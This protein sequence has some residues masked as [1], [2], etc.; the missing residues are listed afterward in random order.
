MA[1]SLTNVMDK[2]LARGL[3]ALRGQTI[4]PSLVNS[5]YSTDAAEKG[6]T[7]DVPVPV[8]QAATAVS[9][10][11]TPPADTDNTPKK[12]QISL[13]QWYS[14]DFH[15]T[16]KE[17]AE[18]DRNRHFF[19]M[20]ASEAIKALASQVNTNIFSHYTGVYGFAGTSGTTPFASTINVAGT[21]AKQL[22][23]QLAPLRDRRMVIDTAAHANAIVLAPL[24]DASQQGTRETIMEG[25]I[26][27]VMG[28][29]WAFD[30]EVPTHTAGTLSDGSGRT[31]LINNGAGYAV[32]T[33]TVNID[34]TSL[35]GTLVTGDIIDFGV[36]GEFYTVTGG[37]HTA[38][39]NA[40]TGLTF[41]PGLRTAVV[42][43][44]AG[45]AQASHTVNLAFHR[46][47]FAFATRPLA[48]EMIEGLGNVFRSMQDPVSGLVLRLEVSRQ[49]KQTK[50]EF[51]MLWGAALVRAELAAR[52]AG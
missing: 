44:Q 4:M 38:S 20:Q 32:G 22:N 12:V 7:I 26:G 19:P 42:D 47:A 17:Q 39:A 43:N 36:T 3:L 18:V 15:L 40:I 27:R 6:D 5:S 46:D 24:R 1:N 21:V 11:P 41:T 25:M 45:E 13:D 49:H 23:D 30:Q 8:A 50:W 48:G 10:G 14:S 52:L 9:P 35:T 31:F 34:N 33:T 51:D 16:D 37:P 2:I 29:D 28:F